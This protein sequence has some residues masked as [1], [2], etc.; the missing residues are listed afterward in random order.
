MKIEVFKGLVGLYKD[1]EKKLSPSIDNESVIDLFVDQDAVYSQARF[2]VGNT[3]EQTANLLNSQRE[4][5]YKII[6]TDISAVL[7]SK[8]KKRPDSD[9]FIGQPQIGQYLAYTQVPANPFLTIRTDYRPGAFIEIRRIALMLSALNG[10]VVVQL[11]LVKEETGAVLKTWDINVN[12]LSTTAKDVEKFKIACDG[13]SYRVEYDY[14]SDKIRVPSSDYHCSCGNVLKSA[15][16]FILE[17]RSK[18]YGIS[19]Y[20]HVG[21]DAFSDVKALVT[22]EPYNLV[23]GMMLRK[24]VIELTLRHIQLLDD[25]NRFTLLSPEEIQKQIDAYQAEY[26]ERLRWI[27][28]QNDF[29]ADE[30]CVKCAQKGPRV[31]NLLT[32]VTR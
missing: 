19:L 20:V 8:M 13:S 23:V 22:Q 16:G 14:D 11:R 7:Q 6:A 32:G 17:N 4:E 21:C 27:A 9:Y 26:D 1:P 15:E 24:K 29:E 31:T 10:P 3:K 30:F 18:T 5:A 2:Q 28:F 25:V 12:V